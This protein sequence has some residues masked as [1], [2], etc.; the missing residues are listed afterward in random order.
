MQKAARSL[1]FVILISI[2]TAQYSSAAEKVQS[3]LSGDIL[4]TVTPVRRP[5][6]TGSIAVT[7]SVRNRSGRRLNLS[8][9]PSLELKGSKAGYWAPFSFESPP[10]SMVAF[11]RCAL[12][13]ASGATFEREIDLKNLLWD[14]QIS[15]MWPSHPLAIVPAGS[16]LLTF[17][18]TIEV[19]G[20]EVGKRITSKPVPITIP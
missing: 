19:I 8:V 6:R 4:C 16:Y 7:V 3:P 11:R 13:L 12:K 9:I 1:A 2:C 18:I 10:D 20:P 17:T 14:L 15:S 5:S